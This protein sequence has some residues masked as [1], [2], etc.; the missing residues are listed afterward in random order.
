MNSKSAIFYLRHSEVKMLEKAVTLMMMM[1]M[2]IIAILMIINLMK[3]YVPPGH[4]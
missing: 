4:G 3:K 1:M 2:T